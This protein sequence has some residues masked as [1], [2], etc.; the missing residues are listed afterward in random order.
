MAAFVQAPPPVITPTVTSQAL[1]FGV[2]VTVGDMLFAFVR[3]V[4]PQTVTDNLGDGVPWTR[5]APYW[6]NNTP[7]DKGIWAKIAGSSGPCTVTAQTGT[8]GTARLAIREYSGVSINTVAA[9]VTLTNTAGASSTVSVGPTSPIPA[10][11]LVIAGGSAP[12]STTLAAGAASP[13][14]NLVKLDSTANGIIGIEDEV[15]WAGGTCTATMVTGAATTLD[16]FVIA[17]DIIR[18]DAAAVIPRTGHF[19]PF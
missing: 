6:G 3:E 17:F 5:L 8:S 7:P 14:S 18:S 16:M 12:L 10:G 9:P 4:S 11:S 1:A 19:G 15:N 13:N 2:D